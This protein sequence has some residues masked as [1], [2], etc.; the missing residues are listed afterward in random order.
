VDD[1]GKKKSTEIEGSRCKKD[2]RDGRDII[3]LENF[4]AKPKLDSLAEFAADRKIGAA[5]GD[6][7]GIR[8]SGLAGFF[9][10]LSTVIWT[11]ALSRLDWSFDFGNAA[12]GGIFL[13]LEGVVAGDDALGIAAGELDHAL[14]ILDVGG[15]IGVGECGAGLMLGK[16]AV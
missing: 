11:Y 7:P 5:L 4:Q 13:E 3:S 10:R 2:S 14:L 15:M 6:V 9:G 1:C 16:V 8:R 12:S